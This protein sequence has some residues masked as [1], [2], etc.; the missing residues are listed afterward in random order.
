MPFNLSNVFKE[1]IYSLEL[2]TNFALNLIINYTTNK[3]KLILMWIC[4]LITKN[5]HHY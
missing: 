3:K 4:L 2:Q 5:L 1:I